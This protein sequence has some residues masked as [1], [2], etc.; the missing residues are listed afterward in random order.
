MTDPMLR[1]LGK[2]EDVDGIPAALGAEYGRVRIEAGASV[3]LLD[4][5]KAQEFARLFTAACWEAADQNAVLEHE[6]PDG[7]A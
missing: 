3:L 6:N 2:V 5:A 4:A 1:I 7:P